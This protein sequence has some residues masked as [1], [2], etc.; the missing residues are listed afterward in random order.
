[1]WPGGE[2]IKNACVICPLGRKAGRG[3]LELDQGGQRQRA[4]HPDRTRK[5]DGMDTETRR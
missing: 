1:M 3:P 2:G 4:A 5:G